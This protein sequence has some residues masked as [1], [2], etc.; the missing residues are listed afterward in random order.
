LRTDPVT[1]RPRRNIELDFSPEQ[2]L[3]PPPTGIRPTKANRKEKLTIIAYK[4]YH[5]GFYW[6]LGELAA[7][8]LSDAELKSQLAMIAM[9]SK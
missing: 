4:N 1:S 8:R 3:C 7:E 9:I 2:Y 6:R 5:A